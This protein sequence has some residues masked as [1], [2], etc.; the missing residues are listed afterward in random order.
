[1]E[2]YLQVLENPKPPLQEQIHGPTA[3]AHAH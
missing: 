3:K 2:K 1:M